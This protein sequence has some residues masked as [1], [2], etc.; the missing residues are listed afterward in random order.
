MKTGQLTGI[1]ASS[2]KYFFNIDEHVIAQ[3]LMVLAIAFLTA[4]SYAKTVIL[5]TYSDSFNSQNGE[6][7]END[8]SIS[9]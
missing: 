8:I 5:N 2:A 4:F 9:N 3:F 7:Y 6:Q 1:V